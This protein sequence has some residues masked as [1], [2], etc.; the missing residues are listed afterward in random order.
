[1]LQNK[2]FLNQTDFTANHDPRSETISATKSA[3]T[4]I[5]KKV[6]RIYFLGNAISVSNGADLR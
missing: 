1:M 3:T 6:H 4:N 2:I 5:D